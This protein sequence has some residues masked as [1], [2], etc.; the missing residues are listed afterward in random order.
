MAKLIIFIFL[1][2]QILAD[3]IIGLW[4]VSTKNAVVDIYKIGDEYKAKLKWYLVSD[5]P[6]KNLRLDRMNPNENLRNRSIWDID[7]LYGLRKVN[8]R[9]EDGK[10]YNAKTGFTY[11]AVIDLKDNNIMYLRGYI[12]F[13]FIGRE[14]YWTRINQK[15]LDSINKAN[16]IPK[17]YLKK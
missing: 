9:W 6:E 12:L 11:S 1:S 8:D 2:F 16:P 15:Q 17:I 10:I 13:E 14:D 5:N 7:V 3:D 4:L